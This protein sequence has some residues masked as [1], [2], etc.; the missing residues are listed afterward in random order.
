MLM[1]TALQTREEKLYSS[2]QQ[3]V[4]NLFLPFLQRISPERKG[5]DVG[6][7]SGLQ[8]QLIKISSVVL[9]YVRQQGSLTLQTFNDERN[10][11]RENVVQWGQLLR[12]QSTAGAHEIGQ[13]LDRVGMKI[14]NSQF[15][16]LQ[17]FGTIKSEMDQQAASVLQSTSVLAESVSVRQQH[18]LEGLAEQNAIIQRNADVLLE[19]SKLSREAIDQNLRMNKTLATLTGLNLEDR[20]REIVQ[21]MESH[22]K[23]IEASV[24]VL[25]HNSAITGEV[26][27]AQTSLHDS[28][29]KLHETGLVETLR[30]FRNSLTDLKPVLENLREPFILQAIP[31]NKD[32]MSS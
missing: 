18:T 20:A 1:A 26:L 25:T 6:S 16:F 17:R 27:A 29:A 23:E 8:E 4:T 24:S 2:V 28:I 22:K 21:I 3:R 14:S 7:L 13:A 9:D 5:E 19:L 15:D 12:E 32:R 11:L 10:L 31:V 30:E